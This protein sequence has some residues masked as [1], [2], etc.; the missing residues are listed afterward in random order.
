MLNATVTRVTSS[1][2]EIRSCHS[3]VLDSQCR[4][5]AAMDRTAVV[6]DAR[7][8]TNALFPC[9]SFC[10]QSFCCPFIYSF[11]CPDRQFMADTF[12]IIH[13]FH[14]RPV[15]HSDSDLESEKR[16]NTQQL[17]SRRELAVHWAVLRVLLHALSLR[18]IS[19]LSEKLF[20]LLVQ[21]THTGGS[22]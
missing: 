17:G 2:M 11:V 8:S 12:I 13:S 7:L 21:F 14:H 20:S 4:R 22:S 16:Q 15:C 6:A 18:F 5:S 9:F 1:S 3:K 19:F 10:R